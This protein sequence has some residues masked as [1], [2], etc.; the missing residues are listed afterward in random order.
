MIRA[1]NNKSYTISELLPKW[2]LDRPI[3]PKWNTERAV[4]R[5]YKG[6]SYV[7]ACVNRIAKS[8]ASVPWIVTEFN[9]ETGAY[10]HLPRH[11]LEILLKKPNP[12]MNGSDLMERL[13]IFLFMGGNGILSKVRANRILAE[14][15]PLPPDGIRPVPSEEDFIDA[16][17][18]DYRGVK[19]MIPAEDIVHLMFP[20]P[21]NVYWGMSPL[22]AMSKT[23]SIELE[24]LD[25][26]KVSFENRAIAD[27]VFSFEHEITK[28]QFD[29]ARRYIRDQ[30]GVREPWVLGS[31]AKWQQM[32]L[33]AVEMDFI[34]S[35]KFTREEI[36]A[37]LGVPPPMIGLYERATMANIREARRIF[38]IDTIIPLLGTIQ[39]AF[40]LFLAPE[41]GNEN[42]RIEYDV[43]GVEA[44]QENFADKVNSAKVL[45]E[46]GVPFNEIN[47]LMEIGFDEMQGGNV[48]YIGQMPAMRTM[49]END[50][51]EDLVNDQIAE[52]ME[53]D[54]NQ[55]T[56]SIKSTMD[57]G[58]KYHLW[59][60]FDE[61]R[62]QIER[63]KA[64]QVAA[65]F[66]EEKRA[67]TG[68]F[69]Q[70]G[71]PG[72][73]SY[74]NNQARSD[75][76]TF[77]A[78]IY[79]ETIPQFA[80]A[81]LERLNNPKN[82]RSYNRKQFDPDRAGLD[83]WINETSRRKSDL[84]NSTSQEITMREL[85]RALAEEET[86]EQILA[87]IEEIYD[88]W[89]N[90]SDPEEY[91]SRSFT[92][93]EVEVGEAAGYGSFQGAVQT[94][95]DLNKEWVTQGDDRVRDSHAILDGEMIPMDDIFPNGLRFPLDSEGPIEEIA[96][97]RCFVLYSET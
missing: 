28:E 71:V 85:R 29:G 95:L 35:R 36:C 48:G 94:E 57:E 58:K 82:I 30:K 14:L 16:Y 27:G 32:S 42:V 50:E 84:I 96:N 25:W 70:D 77:L 13:V 86:D 62:Q 37:V 67:I 55:Q 43:T 7:Y 31:G 66:R 91:H 64:G 4:K 61:R 74:Y 2:M 11:P 72:V 81:E 1:S 44:L 47:A 38:W 8:V 78:E 9:E 39:S 46:M 21:S 49:V 88:D 90:V 65:M 76:E 80:E 54:R 26:Q 18:Y 87:N 73:L 45:W 97:C 3:I 5:S 79:E 51:P 10:E 6:S 93:S 12:W 24:A 40:N 75:W 20:D 53:E 92:I 68:A 41:F 56:R 15:Y 33:N 22:E 17:E 52:D 19:K 63:N 89:A 59:K 69:R 83:F 34:N 23:L 60:S